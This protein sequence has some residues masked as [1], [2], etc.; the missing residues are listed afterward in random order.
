MKHLRRKRPTDR[1]VQGLQFAAARV[2]ASALTSLDVE[3]ALRGARATGRL[4]HRFD[5]R[6]RLRVMRQL[7]LALP[8][9]PHARREAA[10]QRAFEHCLQIVVEMCFTP[11]LVHR[12]SWSGR[13]VFGDLSPL[14]R[15][16]NAGK[17]AVLVTGHVGNWEVL[18]FIM[19]VLGYSM[20]ALYRPLDNPFLNQWLVSV[21]QQRGLQLV[22]KWKAAD[23]MKDVLAEGGSLGFIADQDAGERGIFVPFFGHLASTYKSVGLLATSHQVPVLCGWARRRGSGFGFELVL[24]DAI[25]PSDWERQ[26]DP[27]YYVTARFMRAIE[28]MV[29][30]A[31]DQYIWFQ[32]R[33]RSRPRFER[34]GE[35]MPD[36]LR[37]QL[38]SLPWMD[39][40]TM[41]RLEEPMIDT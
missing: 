32:R 13:A 37:Q 7:A 29:R 24:E 20:H 17:P 2:A 25:Y 26:P 14:L 39:Q 41:N 15:T 40:A 5:H 35:S 11:R 34:R 22:S 1:F 12:D 30:K 16:L 8:E 9:W 6:H 33:W 3:T 28:S 23:R 18:G 36:R 38:E 4:V 21:R 19:A 31:P 27:L 10:C